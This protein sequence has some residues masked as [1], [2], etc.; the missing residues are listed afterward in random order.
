MKGAIIGD[1][2]AL[3]RGADGDL[4]SSRVYLA[5]ALALILAWIT[6]NLWGPWDLWVL[7]VPQARDPR[8]FELAFLGA[9]VLYFTAGAYGKDALR[10]LLPQVGGILERLAGRGGG[11]GPSFGRFE[12]GEPPPRPVDVPREEQVP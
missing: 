12:W 1:E 8:D 7:T 10:H 3:L 11:S 2:K 9:L 4:S 6:S 5:T